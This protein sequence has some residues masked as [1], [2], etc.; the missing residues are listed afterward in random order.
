VSTESVPSI[1]GGSYPPRVVVM[2]AE[3]PGAVRKLA[4]QLRQGRPVVLIWSDGTEKVVY[5]DHP[6]TDDELAA[7]LRELSKWARIEQGRRTFIT[8]SG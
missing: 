1:R 2:S 5:T 3:K 6:L 8:G 4:R 7:T